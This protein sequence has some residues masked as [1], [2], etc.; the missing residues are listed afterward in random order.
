MSPG[1]LS[2]CQ[3]Q[4]PYVS[5]HTSNILTRVLQ[6]KGSARVRR[7]GLGGKLA[8]HT[9]V[10]PCADSLRCP[11]SLGVCVGLQEVL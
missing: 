8:S 7:V 11:G 3:C 10:L 9:S 4:P 5:Q 6:I 1:L 2:M